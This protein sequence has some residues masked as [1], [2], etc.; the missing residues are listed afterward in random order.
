MAPTHQRL[1]GREVEPLSK[2][3]RRLD[4]GGVQEEVRL[5][6]EVDQDAPDVDVHV[7]Q[8]LPK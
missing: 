1:K 7:I 8:D 2:G 5:F 4:V 3:C 6:G